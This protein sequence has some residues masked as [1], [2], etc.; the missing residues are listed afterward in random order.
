MVLGDSVSLCPTHLYYHSQYG[1]LYLITITA[2]FSNFIS[3]G[4]WMSKF[5]LHP[6]CRPNFFYLCISLL[7]IILKICHACYLITSDDTVDLVCCLF[8]FLFL[9]R[10]FFNIYK[11]SQAILTNIYRC[12]DSDI[13]WGNSAYA[14][15]VVHLLH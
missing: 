12:I 9:L 5:D 6:L 2:P 4:P 15:G 14:V 8:V 1:S 10:L 7:P 11:F 3:D 13:C